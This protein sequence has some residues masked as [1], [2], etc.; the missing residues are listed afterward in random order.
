[1]TIRLNNYNNWVHPKPTDAD[2][3]ERVASL[4]KRDRIV[5]SEG[6]EQGSALTPESLRAM[7]PD[8]KVYRLFTLTCKCRWESDWN[9]DREWHS[10]NC[11]TN[12]VP[13]QTI[14]KN[15]WWLR[16][17]AGDV[18]CEHEGCWLVDVGKP[19]Y[20]EA[21]LTAILARM[22]GKAH[23]G[24]VF[25]YHGAGAWHAYIGWNATKSLQGYASQDA[26]AQATDEMLAYVMSGIKAQTDLEIVGNCAG[27]YIN[28]NVWQQSFR[29]MVDGNIYELM[30]INGQ[31]N[32]I[33]EQ[34]LERNIL[35]LLDDPM[36]VW[37][38][39]FGL[40]GPES[41]LDEDPEYNQKFMAS[42][43]AYYMGLPQDAV[44]RERRSYGAY[45]NSRVFWEPMFD[46]DLGQPLA[47]PVKISSG[48]WRRE[49]TKGLVLLNWSAVPAAYD[50]SG[51]YKYL[52][53]Q[54]ARTRVTLE[55]KTALFLQPTTVARI[56][57]T[58]D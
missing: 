53:G 12:P 44:L 17:G 49:Y 56:V 13:Y 24:I 25:D 19:G 36:E 46:L 26:Y 50:I 2:Y 45:N 41:V 43:A 3:A 15:D 28:P 7:N 14:V 32:R 22:A 39:E 57:R 29:T 10:Q 47:R 48:V 4:V 9:Y 34:E 58:A 55:P 31:Y 35:S 11:L 37:T 5:M 18:V 38:S 27:M 30:T 52:S 33:S 54:R 6:Y 1:M 8:T 51:S 40:I 20:K 21:M 23:D 42:V 16:D